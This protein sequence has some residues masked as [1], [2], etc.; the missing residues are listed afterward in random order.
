VW[1]NALHYELD[2]PYADL[3]LSE[4]TARG[5]ALL[6]N[7]N[8]FFMMVEGG[9]I[10]WAC[11]ARDAGTAI[12][13]ILALDRALAEAV[14][15]YHQHPN[16]TLIV[17]TGDHECGGLSIDP[18]VVRFPAPLESIRYQTMSHA[19]FNEKLAE[20][21]QQHSPEDSDFED[22]LP[23]IERAF[24]LKVRPGVDRA[25]QEV[26]REQRNEESRRELAA[27][28]SIKEMEVL[29][30]AFRQSMMGEEQRA[31]DDYIYQLYGGFDPL[32]V[33]LTTILN[34]KCGISWTSDSHTG[35]PVQTSAL[36]VGQG[37]FCGYYDNTHVPKV[38][39]ALAG[40]GV[41]LSSVPTSV[42]GWATAP[43]LPVSA[44]AH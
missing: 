2:R 9:K 25:P 10:D 34:E 20:Y 11:H 41:R 13:E 43:V 1:G 4:Y 39:M 24:G 5:I 29:R 40:F 23:L 14:R 15:F 18:R 27:S 3:T 12:H 28:L 26:W 44:G 31:E 19:A 21:K 6:D 8:G 7:P 37:Y 22:I 36:G 38:I 17:A 30:K 33:K 35:V 42:A 16:E 32:T